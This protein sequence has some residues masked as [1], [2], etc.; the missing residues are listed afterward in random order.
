M[1]A[2]GIDLVKEIFDSYNPQYM[3]DLYFFT[4]DY[5]CRIFDFYKED[6]IR[7]YNGILPFKKE[8]IKTITRE[9]FEKEYGKYVFYDVNTYKVNWVYSGYT[10]NN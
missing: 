9:E 3:Y 6:D 1:K 7:T 2:I 4:E 5:G 10:W 8:V